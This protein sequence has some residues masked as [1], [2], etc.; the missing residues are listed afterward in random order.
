LIVALAC[1]STWNVLWS[2]YAVY[3]RF[4]V[5]PQVALD[6]GMTRFF[7]RVAAPFALAGVFSRVYSSIDSIL[8]SKFVSE[9]AVGVYGVGY[10]VAFAFQFLPMSLAAAVYPA[11]SESY[12]SNRE[13]LVQVFRTALKYLFVLVVPLAAG[14][15]LLADR[16]LAAVYG[17]A[18]SA[19]DAP[20][21]I[22]MVSLIFAFLYW[23]AGSL[24]N[25]CDRER[26]N[27]A[28]MGCTMIGNILLNLI[29]IPRFGSVGAAL[30]ALAGNAGLF[31]G[32]AV[33]AFRLVRPPLKP[34][35]RDAVKV[36]ASAA[37]MSG[38]VI[39]AEPIAP[40][41]ALIPS[42]MVVYTLSLFALRGVTVEECRT[43]IGIFTRRTKTVSDIV[44][45]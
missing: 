42:A 44:P 12:V 5:A 6:P 19:A 15:G 14:I 36:L 45:T 37:V 33:P 35:L 27:T 2:T 30:A 31:L 8:L 3:R 38:V 10:K 16:L 29:L 24:L 25:A 28:V 4:R 39:A 1:G 41:A 18:F 32:A 43:I 40:L 34:M 21:Q 22:L 20:L 11:M 26:I 13:R 9:A 23:P 7:L 17:H